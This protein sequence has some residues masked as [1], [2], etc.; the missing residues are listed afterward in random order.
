VLKYLIVVTVLFAFSCAAFAQIPATGAFALMSI[1]Q[2][3]DTCGGYT[4]VELQAAQGYAPGLYWDVMNGI[5][6]LNQLEQPFPANTVTP[7]TFVQHQIITAPATGL[8]VYTYSQGGIVIF[9]GIGPSV[10]GMCAGIPTAEA[11]C[12]GIFWWFNGWGFTTMMQPGPFGPTLVDL[13]TGAGA[14]YANFVAQVQALTSLGVRNSGSWIASLS[15]AGVL[16]TLPCPGTYT[17]FNFGY[18]LIHAQYP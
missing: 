4:T 18:C 9:L 2:G 13:V 16:T 5:V 11:S 14:T 10:N 15:A 8:N 6:S 7:N 1:C 3:Y 17:G 12:V